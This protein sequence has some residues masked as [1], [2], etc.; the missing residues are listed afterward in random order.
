M[1]A[2]AEFVLLYW[3]SEVRAVLDSVYRHWDIATV[4]Y[5]ERNAMRVCELTDRCTKAK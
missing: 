4:G 3:G 2:P 1:Y 5:K